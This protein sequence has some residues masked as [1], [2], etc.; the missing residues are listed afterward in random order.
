[1]STAKFQEISQMIQKR[2]IWP[3]TELDEDNSQAAKDAFYRDNNLVFPEFVHEK[4]K[5][6][7]LIRNI[8]VLKRTIPDA[9]ERSG[10]TKDEKAVLEKS[11]AWALKGNEYVVKALSRFFP[12]PKELFE[13]QPEY[14]KQFYEVVLDKESLQAMSLA[15]YG[16][17]IDSGLVSSLLND[18]LAVMDKNDGNWQDED[19]ELVREIGTILS[20]HGLSKVWSPSFRCDTPI[21]HPSDETVRKFGELAKLNLNRIL[22][23]LPHKEGIYPAEEVVE[24]TNKILGMEYKDM[25]QYRAAVNEK[26]RIFSV[27]TGKYIAK[28]PRERSKGPIDYDTLYASWFG[29]EIGTHVL[30]A[31]PYEDVE[32]KEFSVGYT[33]YEGMEEGIAK[34]VEKALLFSLGN[35]ENQANRSAIDYYVNIGLAHF[36]GFN[37]RELWT[38]RRNIIYLTSLRNGSDRAQL[39]QRAMSNA[40]DQ[41]RRVFRGTGDTV[42]Y[43][44]LCYYVAEERVWK[45]IEQYIH[46]DRSEELWFTL[47]GLGKVNLFDADTRSVL[48]III[49]SK[50]FPWTEMRLTRR[51]IL[52]GILDD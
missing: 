52:P 5:M 7:R 49:N 41:I 12:D 6:L 39:M 15:Y 18:T 30:R 44:D 48:R 17:Q 14:L 51:K 27:D 33:C 46:I 24:L 43:K 20:L 23:H 4:S 29:H 3:H 32:M 13:G 36:Y 42:E 38:L 40:Y 19:L 16:H 35:T 50:D 9:I 22:R 47:M 10:C 8:Y 26:G 45:L 2:R 34:C 11:L 28:V 21:Y 1:M 37:F 25:T 31:I